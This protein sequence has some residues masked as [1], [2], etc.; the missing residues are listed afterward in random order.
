MNSTTTY[1]STA[2]NSTTDS[3][4]D[5]LALVGRMLLAYF[6]VPSGI[7]KLMHFAGTV[8]YIAKSGVPL[9]EVCA[10]IAVAVELGFALLLLFG[11]QTR[12]VAL[13]MA[14]FVL[15]ITPIF[16]HYWSVPEAQ[17]AAQKMNFS[18]NLA[19]LGGLLAFAAFGAGRFSIDGRRRD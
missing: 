7:G 10:A 5:T 13:G 4:Q 17:I 2:M 15:V 19:I 14:I 18:K 3:L 6:F 16:H 1:N 8:D 11:W 12:W 9:P